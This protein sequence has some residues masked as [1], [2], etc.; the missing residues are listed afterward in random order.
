MDIIRIV[1]TLRLWMISPSQR[2][3]GALL[4][5]AS[6]F[7]TSKRFWNER[8]KTLQTKE[9]RS[10]GK[11]VSRNISPSVLEPK[12]RDGG[13]VGPF[14]QLDVGWVVCGRET[15]RVVASQLSPVSIRSSQPIN[16]KP[17]V[18]RIVRNSLKFINY[19]RCPSTHLSTDA[20]KGILHGNLSGEMLSKGLF[21]CCYIAR[22]SYAE[23]C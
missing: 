17:W 12:E 11:Y 16:G 15:F 8:V 3:D 1:Q 22:T 23:T 21:I 18:G 5:D 2:W 6:C 10:Q 19:I 14:V 20:L 13:T 4:Y 7:Q 9:P